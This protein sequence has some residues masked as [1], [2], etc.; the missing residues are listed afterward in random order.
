MLHCPISSTLMQDGYILCL[1]V[2]YRLS[3]LHCN[4]VRPSFFQRHSSSNPRWMAHKRTVTVTLLLLL[5]WWA[6]FTMMMFTKG[7][8]SLVVVQRRTVSKLTP[9]MV[10][11]SHSVYSTCVKMKNIFNNKLIQ[12][13]CSKECCKKGSYC[14]NNALYTISYYLLPSSMHKWP[15]ILSFYILHCSDVLLKSKI[16]NTCSF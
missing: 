16:S 1:T 6:P 15:Y 9:I 10:Y 11:V 7:I 4:I 14:E 3:A 2:T 8:K 13:H 12:P 5:G